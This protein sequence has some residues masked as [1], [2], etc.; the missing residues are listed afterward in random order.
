LFVDGSHYEATVPTAR[1]SQALSS[2]SN[3]NAPL[4]DCGTRS[5]PPRRVDGRAA[6]GTGRV[7]AAGLTEERLRQLVV[8]SPWPRRLKWQV[9]SSNALAS[10]CNNLP[11]KVIRVDRLRSLASRPLEWTASVQV[12]LGSPDRTIPSGPRPCPDPLC[13][14]PQLV[15]RDRVPAQSDRSASVS[16]PRRLVRVFL[17]VVVSS[18]P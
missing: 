5:F 6:A 17:G 14:W 1:S 11:H 9:F 2:T 15:D 13:N 7:S 10:P 8:G 3:L 4:K 12:V 18:V 16:L